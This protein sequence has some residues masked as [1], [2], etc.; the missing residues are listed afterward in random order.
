MRTEEPETISIS[1]LCKAAGV[2]R[3]TFYQHFGTVDDVLAANVQDHLS[4]ESRKLREDPGVEDALARSLLYVQEHR[5]ELALTLD[6][7]RGVP[8]A[9]H[10]TIA[11]LR[12][13]VAR[14]R[15]RTPFAQ[16]AP[17]VQAPVIF[18]VGGLV[19]VFE[20]QLREG[21]TEELDAQELSRSIR[22]AMDTV[23]PPRDPSTD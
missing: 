22:A 19:A 21:R 3:P 8:R 17:E 2:S 9:R 5:D 14:A 18:A 7:R 23:L 16:L 6:S 15:F 11:W 20:D 13:T 10:A 4:E 12:D 1:R